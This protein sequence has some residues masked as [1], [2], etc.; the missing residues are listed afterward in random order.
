[1]CSSLHLTSKGFLILKLKGALLLLKAVQLLVAMDVVP[2]MAHL[3]LS[4]V[5]R[6]G[7][8]SLSACTVLLE[9]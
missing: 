1:M 4:A 7:L 5:Q 6:A 3:Y 2:G 8:V 9:S